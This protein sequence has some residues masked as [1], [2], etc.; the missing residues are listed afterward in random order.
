MS[1]QLQKIEIKFFFANNVQFMPSKKLQHSEK[2]N[3]LSYK[4]LTK[5]VVELLEHLLELQIE[6]TRSVPKYVY[7]RSVQLH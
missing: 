3:K 1:Q 5:S 7:Q 2:K 4:S 6:S